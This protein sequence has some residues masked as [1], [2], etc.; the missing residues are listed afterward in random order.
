MTDVDNR[1]TILSKAG[2][3]RPPSANP[4][5]PEQETPNPAPDKDYSRD[6]APFT[7]DEENDP[8]IEDEYSK[9]ANLD[10]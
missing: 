6:R 1:I 2:T 3:N 7:D 5:P 4:M 8:E 9:R 10:C